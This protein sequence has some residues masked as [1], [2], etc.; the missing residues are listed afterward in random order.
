MPRQLFSKIISPRLVGL[1]GTFC[2]GKDTAANYLVKHKG[3]MHV[4]TGDVLRSVATHQGKNHDRTTLIELGVKLRSEYGSLGALVL[5][6]IE[7][8]QDQKD[9]FTGGLVVSGLRVVAE[10]QEIKDQNGILLFIDAPAEVRYN[11]MKERAKKEGR[12]I[13]L[14]DINNLEDFEAHERTELL[15][16]GGPERPNLRAVESI[17]DFVIQNN[18][19][20]DQYLETIDQVVA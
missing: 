8:W 11:R 12:T 13:D 6:G 1:S 16:L 7:Q 18:I 5:K 15:G 20:K 4:S 3:F 17:S 2:S 9:I 19:P 10:A 14:V